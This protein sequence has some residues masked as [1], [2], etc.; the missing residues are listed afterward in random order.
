LAVTESKTLP[1]GGFQ[2]RSGR[3]GEKKNQIFA[4]SEIPQSRA[5]TNQYH[6]RIFFLQAKGLQFPLLIHC[7]MLRLTTRRVVTILYQ[8]CPR[9]SLK[10]LLY[11][12][13]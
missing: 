13:C 4:P 7:K 8:Q 1:P 2:N 10:Q 12:D 9:H 5:A 6:L 3:R 11:A